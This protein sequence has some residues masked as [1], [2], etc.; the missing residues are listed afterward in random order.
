M[1]GTRANLERR[2]ARALRRHLGNGGEASLHEAYTFGR[3]AL[4]AD[5]GVLEMT[6]LLWRVVV[7]A[8]PAS[9]DPRLASQVEAFL[10]ECLS[11]FEMA[12]RAAREG[13]AAL[14]RLD[15]RREEHVRR[16]ARELHDQAGQL[17]ATVYLSLDAVK[18]HLAEGGAQP[19]ARVVSLLHRVED[20]MSRVAYELRP[21]ILDDLGLVPA[22]RVLG[23]G[24]AQR[25]ALTIHVEGSTRGRLPPRIE[26][27]LYRMVQEA[28]GHVARDTG[29]SQAVVALC[30][31]E[32]EVR[33]GVRDNG[34]GFDP[35]RPATGAAMGLDGIRER[36]APLGG[37]MEVR[38]AEGQGTELV[39]RVPLEVNGAKNTSHR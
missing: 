1:S 24:M 5:I 34:R 32:R 33:C 11:P 30:H 31:T 36:L 21:V 3:A 10:L 18:P 16:V 2:G 22:L 37:S 12:H 27:E 35:A 19:L 6:V 20:E 17:L 8:L 39:I 38:S 25:S 7:G 13:N 9:G 15:E 26:T 23:E 28:L 4:D 29:A 14:R